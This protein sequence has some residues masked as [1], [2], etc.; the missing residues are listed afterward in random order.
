MNTNYLEISTKQAYEWL[1]T[2]HWGL[3]Q[4]ILWLKA[5]NLYAATERA[6]YTN[7]GTL[8]HRA[9]ST[10]ALLMIRNK[11]WTRRQFTNWL[12]T[13]LSFEN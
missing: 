1:K 5:K 9:D 2:C 10:T 12:N 13:M 3:H 4:F 7:G 11:N 6:H 8:I